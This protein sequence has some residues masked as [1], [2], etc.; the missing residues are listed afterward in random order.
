MLEIA[1]KI[2]LVVFLKDPIPRLT[3]N[4]LS[5]SLGKVACVRQKTLAYHSLRA[6]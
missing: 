4:S 6:R 1:D 5:F 2:G 3:Q